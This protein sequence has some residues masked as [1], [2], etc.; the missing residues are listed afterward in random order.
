MTVTEFLEHVIEGYRAPRWKQ[1]EF[2]ERNRGTLATLCAS[3]CGVTYG[4]AYATVLGWIRRQR[5]DPN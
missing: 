1:V 5:S 2:V 4:E 3:R